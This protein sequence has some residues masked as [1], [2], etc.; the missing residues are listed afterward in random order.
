[1]LTPKFWIHLRREGFVKTWTRGHKASRHAHYIAGNRTDG[2][3]KQVGEDDFGNR[4][5]EDFDVDRKLF[6]ILLKYCL[7]IKW[8]LLLLPFKWGYFIEIIKVK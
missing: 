3:S 1:M 7:I 2:Y 6:F 4:Y 8:F 5:Y